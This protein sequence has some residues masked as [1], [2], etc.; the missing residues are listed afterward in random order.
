MAEGKITTILIGV[1]LFIMAA[2][3]FG[4]FMWGTLDEYGESPNIV[5]RNAFVS[6]SGIIRNQTQTM[7]EKVEEVQTSTG[8][9]DVASFVVTGGYAAAKI[10]ISSIG[11]LWGV[12]T[13]ILSEETGLGYFD[14]GY[15]Q[16]ILMVIIATIVVLAV[17][18]VVL[19]REL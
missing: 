17:L 2:A 13:E 1:L 14:I 12:V 11:I 9:W 10:S 3:A 5:G 16:D 6:H 15:V 4:S 19:K 18:N 8:I 7:Q